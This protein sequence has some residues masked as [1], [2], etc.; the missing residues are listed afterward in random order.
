[1]AEYNVAYRETIILKK[2]SSFTYIYGMGSELLGDGIYSINNNRLNLNFKNVPIKDTASYR[3]IKSGI[4]EDRFSYKFIVKAVEDSL[5]LHDAYIN[6]KYN[7]D[8]NQDS[9][10][11]PLQF[12]TD[13]KGIA[14]INLPKKQLPVSV[15]ITWVGYKPYSFILNDTSSI[16]IEVFMKSCCG[17]EYVKGVTL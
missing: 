12:K 5:P 13:M 9:S 7:N 8:I 10:Y 3:I 15:K 4:T 1:M 17:P 14:L 6:F 2:D 11:F 16:T